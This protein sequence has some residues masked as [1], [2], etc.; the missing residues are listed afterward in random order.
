MGTGQRDRSSNMRIAIKRDDPTALSLYAE[1]VSDSAMA[2]RLGVSSKAVS[3]WRDRK[4]LPHNL[5]R[6]HEQIEK[7]DEYG[8][9]TVVEK[10]T[11]PYVKCECKCGKKMLLR[12]NRLRRGLTNQCKGCNNKRPRWSRHCFPYTEKHPRK[13]VQTVWAAVKRCTMEEHKQYENYGGRGIAIS[14]EWL[15]D[16]CLFVEYLMTLEGWNDASLVLDREDNDGNYEPGNLRFVT[17]S[18]SQ[19]NRRLPTRGRNYA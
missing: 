4:G 11:G 16:P 19:Y 1:G 13:L 3:N 7:D 8:N 9:W 5:S 12:A 15:D 10:P 6:H 14:Q 17:R 2:A 18:D